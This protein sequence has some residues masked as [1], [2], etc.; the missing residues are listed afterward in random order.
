[1]ECKICRK[2]F[3]P[4]HFN[5]KCCSPECK[6]KARAITLR[7][8]KDSDKGK[9]CVDNWCKNP[10]RIVVEKRHRQKPYVKKKAVINSMKCLAN[11]PELQEKKRVRDREYALTEEGRAINKIARKKYSQTAKGKISNINGKA[12]RR[13]LEKTGR[14]TAKEWVEKLKEF[15]YCCNICGTEENI[16]MDHVHPL[17]KGG[18][19]HIDNVQ[20][21]CR[22]CNASKGVKLYG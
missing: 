12:R 8:F 22:S 16:E 11:S 15:G 7:K 17:S 20:P 14:I 5:Q 6:K 10:K 3:S 13:Q 21:L 18:S 4:S 9:K 19:H 1:V 2:L